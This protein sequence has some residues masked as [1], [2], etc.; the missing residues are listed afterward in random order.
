VV[1]RDRLVHKLAEVDTA[2]R[3][4]VAGRIRDLI[5]P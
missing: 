2:R 5:G 4:S 3:A 1:Y